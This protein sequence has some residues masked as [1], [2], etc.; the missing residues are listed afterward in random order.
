MPGS[1]AV[2][3]TQRQMG[4][5]CASCTS[6]LRHCKQCNATELLVMLNEF[7]SR[8]MILALETCRLALLPLVLALAGCAVQ[9]SAYEQAAA[10]PARSIVYIYRPY[11]LMGSGFVP[12]I[13]C[14][15]YSTSLGPEVFT[16]SPST[17]EPSTATFIPRLR[18]RSRSTP[19]QDSNTTSANQ[20]GPAGFLLTSIST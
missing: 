14:G 16:N 12:A 20:F 5:E 2:G 7:N 19:S 9:G 11:N 18:P 8:S 10:P 4:R 3:G 1:D 15:D 13:N 6:S 17:P